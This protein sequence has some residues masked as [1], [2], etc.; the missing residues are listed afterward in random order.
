MSTKRAHNSQP[1]PRPRFYEFSYS[2]VLDLVDTDVILDPSNI[3]VF[4]PFG[5]D[6]AL[7]RQLI[8]LAREVPVHRAI[9]NSKTNYILGQGVQ[10]S[11]PATAAFLQLPN[12]HKELFSVTLKKLCFDYLTFGNCFYELVTNKKRSFVFVY[13]QDASRVRLHTDGKQALIHPNWDLFR[14][15][16]DKH[17]KSISLFPEFS[18]GDDGLLHSIVHIKDYEPEFSWYGIPSYFAGIRNVIISGLTNIW[19]QTRL[20]S[21]FASP[22][23]LVIPGVNSEADATALNTTMAGY[24]GALGT[25]S[26]KIV[27]QFMS[28]PAPGAAVGEVKFVPFSRDNEAHWL[29]LHTQSELSLITIHNW[30]PSL[31]PYSDMKS[32]FESG[33]ILN[34]YEVA[35][36]TVIK[37]IQQ[38]FHQSLQ[39]ALAAC[40]LQLKDFEFINSP[41]VSRINPMN[42]VWEVRRDSGLEFD[43]SDP[44]QNILVLQLQNSFTS[45]NS[46]P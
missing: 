29:D 21:S 7:P 11:D 43:K 46:N 3:K 17:L 37:P 30:F 5:I 42:F 28:D 4:V 24:F 44:A 23:M 39:T 25:N 32:S 45:K 8:K 20:E 26:G 33:R 12:N 16:G 22:G 15:N 31:T 19:N 9:L 34:E 1:S 27:I 14:G 2:P 38:V 36:A 6:N 35:M 41:P 40:G 13:H 18:A 10:S